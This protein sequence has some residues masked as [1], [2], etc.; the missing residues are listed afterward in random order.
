MNKNKVVRL[1]NKTLNVI[2][3]NAS[4]ECRVSYQFAFDVLCD[5]IESGYVVGDLTY[6]VLVNNVDKAKQAK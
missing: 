6:I 3:Q 2:V 1:R 5:M 4:Y